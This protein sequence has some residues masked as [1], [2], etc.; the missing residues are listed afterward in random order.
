MKRNDHEKAS[1]TLTAIRWPTTEDEKLLTARVAD[2]SDF[3]HTDPWRVMRIMA[4]FVEGFDTLAKL[5]PAITLFGSAR[6]KP[7]HPQYAA[8]REVARLI[9]EAGFNIIT[10]G[11]PGVMQAGN[12]GAKAA[13]VVSVGLNIE[14]PFEQGTNQYVEVPINFRYFFI[15]KTMFVKYA[16]GFVIFPGGFG[17]MDELF[18]SL[19]LI[20]TGKVQNFP[21]ILYDSAYWGGLL[22]WLRNTMQ[23]EGKVSAG[24]LNL[25]I[26]ADS[27]DEVRDIILRWCQD[28]QWRTEQE[29]GAR[30]A[31]RQALGQRY[32]PE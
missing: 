16:Q 24:D 22:E 18:E 26:P 2:T 7:D 27:P 9:G 14:L 11:G 17:T 21:V 19:T 25:L 6:T 13:G 1:A 15:R 4:E 3:T 32:N 23:T 28:H 8:A 20:Q 30:L 31:T 10:G 12:E 5:G 29:E